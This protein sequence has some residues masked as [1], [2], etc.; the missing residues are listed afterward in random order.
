MT[1]Q[2][3]FSREDLYFRNCVTYQEVKYTYNLEIVK[4][5]GS[6]ISDMGFKSYEKAHFKMMDL[7]SEDIENVVSQRVYPLAVN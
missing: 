6:V 5:D 3:T 1:N 7:V 4:K 2:K